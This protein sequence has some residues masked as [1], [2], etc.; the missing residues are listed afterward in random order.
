MMTHVLL[1]I[2]A[3]FIAGQDLLL[4][5]TTREIIHNTLNMFKYE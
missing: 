1:T 2:S 3:L 4:E 5:L